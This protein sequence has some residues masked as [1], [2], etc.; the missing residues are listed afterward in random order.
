MTIDLPACFGSSAGN[1]RRC[2]RRF[3]PREPRNHA[4]HIRNSASRMQG[5]DKCLRPVPAR[6]RWQDNLLNGRHC[7][8]TCR[9]CLHRP[10]SALSGRRRISVGI[11]P[12][13]WTIAFYQT[14][15]CTA[16]NKFGWRVMPIGNVLPQ[17]AVK[18]CASLRAI[19]PPAGT[20][21]PDSSCYRERS[22]AL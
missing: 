14:N 16:K 15:Q 2:A 12:V 19:F 1:C 7:L 18:Y 13:F 11:T 10:A 3:R 5:M 21:L 22:S 20:D 6:R 8:H 9:Y 17:L 4:Q